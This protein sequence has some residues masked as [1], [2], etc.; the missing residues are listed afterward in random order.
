MQGRLSNLQVSINNVGER[1]VAS[2]PPSTPTQTTERRND[3]EDSKRGRFGWWEFENRY[4]PYILRT[5]KQ[6]KFTAARMAEHVLL[7]KYLD[8][9][10]KEI[11]ACHSFKAKYITDHEANLL[12]EINSQ[13]SDFSF[14]HVPFKEGV[15]TA[16]ALSDVK[17][18]YGFLELSYNKLLE[19]KSNVTDRCGFFRIN[20]QSVV[21]YTTLNNVKYVPVF[22]FQDEVETLELN[23]IQIDGWDLAYLKFCFQYHGIK[24]KYLE[25]KICNVVSADEIRSHFPEDTS[26][27]DYWIPKGY[28]ESLRSRHE[29]ATHVNKDPRLQSSV[30]DSSKTIELNFRANEQVLSTT[31]QVLRTEQPISSPIPSP[32]PPISSLTLNSTSGNTQPQTLPAVLVTQPAVKLMPFKEFEISPNQSGPPYK[33]HKALIEQKYVTCINVK[34]YVFH[35]LMCTLPEFV[36]NFYPELSHDKAQHVLQDGLK[37]T[38]Y[39]G[40]QSHKELLWREGMSNPFGPVP[41]LL[42]KEIINRLPAI[43]F[44]MHNMTTGQQSAK[45]MRMN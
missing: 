36:R 44:T 45:R 38:L 40:N 25:T 34:P 9:L 29:N 6:D 5:E 32:L 4:V 42:V 35:E 33:V 2:T 10:P 39:E 8:I 3:D 20:G 11:N 27:E 28:K 22:Y 24:N 21:P 26:F 37:F 12:N 23:I 7:N 41:L 18:F 19:H 17:E 1:V 30:E 43:K 16:I 14:G 13:H 15:D 31:D